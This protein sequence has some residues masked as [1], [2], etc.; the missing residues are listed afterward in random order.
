M[1]LKKNDIVKIE[2]TGMT[3]EGSGVGRVEDIAVFIPNTAIGDILN[4]VIIKTSKR[5]AIGKVLEILSP[6]K[7]RIEADCPYFKQCGGCA[8]RHITYDSELSIK[9]QHV[10]D[11]I[12]RIGGFKELKI[13]PIV[14][15]NSRNGYRNKAQFPVGVSKDGNLITGFYAYHSHRIVSCENCFLQPAVFN[16]IALITRKWAEEYKITPYDE[17]THSGTLRHLYI[18]LGESTGEIM[19]CLVVNG[20]R[21]KG[22]KELA[23]RLEKDIPNFKS[24]II[25]ENKEKSNVILGKK[26]TTVYGGEYITDILCGLKFNISPLSFYQVNRTQAEK[27][28]NI[29][30][31]YADLQGDEILLDLYC[32]TGTIGLSMAHKVKELI[33]VEIVEQAVENARANARLNNIGNARF[34]CADASSAAARLEKENIKPDVIILDPPRKGCNNELIS[35]VAHMEPKRVVYVSC[36]AATLARDMKLFAQQGYIPREV[37]PVDMFPV[38]AHVETVCL[39]SKLNVKQHIEVELTMDEMDLTAA[40]KK[41]SY[42]EIKEYVLEKF[43]MKVSH[44]YIAQVKRKCGIIE[45][46]NYNKPK[47]ESAKQPQCPPEKEAAIRAALEYFRMI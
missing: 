3:S 44:L 35:T 41:A 47:S 22:E 27:L 1:K 36:D 18:R 5:Y 20:N 46:E 21:L 8:Y 38:T 39:L 28:Y 45:R 26:C 33:G 30:Q 32:G 14:A 19:V 15:G 24:L 16:D 43:G 23:L 9:E 6:S 12:S 31:N 25:N 42:E 17:K 7:D 34:I 10:K 13:N 29:A 4:A 37:T 40:E 2:I 11:A